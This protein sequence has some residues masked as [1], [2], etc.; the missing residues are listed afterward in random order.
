MQLP[1]TVHIKGGQY[2][3]HR[4]SQLARHV[5]Y[6]NCPCAKV[7]SEQCQWCSW[8]CEVIAVDKNG[9]ALDP[10]PEMTSSAV[11]QEMLLGDDREGRHHVPPHVAPT[12]RDMA[13]GDAGDAGG[14]APAGRGGG[15]PRRITTCRATRGA[16]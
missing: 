3:V 10:Q 5:S 4:A 1:R 2:T 7:S 16:R 11:L 15:P 6:R 14:R 9:T 12:R 13:K 8:R